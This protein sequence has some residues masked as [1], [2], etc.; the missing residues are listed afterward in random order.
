MAKSKREIR[1]TRFIRLLSPELV[2][3]WRQHLEPM[4]LRSVETTK[5]R[6]RAAVVSRGS[7]R[8]ELLDELT[9]HGLLYRWDAD[10]SLRLDCCYVPTYAGCL[11]A[12][13]STR[14][15]TSA[16]RKWL[17]LHPK[18][19]PG[20]S[21]DPRRR[22]QI[23]DRGKQPVI[24]TKERD[25]MLLEFLT[26]LCCYSQHSPQLSDIGTGDQPDQM[27]PERRHLLSL[28][29]FQVAC[30]LANYTVEGE[31]GVEPDVILADLPGKPHAFRWWQNR[32]RRLVKSFGGFRDPGLGSLNSR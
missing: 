23:R 3:Y 16:W 25:L 28:V 15:A 13:L 9:R 31:A 14:A 22:K 10:P 5:T 6:L 1:P 4:I 7:E 18:H 30:L 11:F 21:A 20:W 12:G 26:N 24:D 32:L 19:E 2:V 29:S 8:G 27:E 17:L